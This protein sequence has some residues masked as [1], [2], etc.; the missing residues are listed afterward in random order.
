MAGHSEENKDNAL[1]GQ[2]I[3]RRRMELGL[4]RE[5]L[6]E[7][8]EVSVQFISDIERGNKSMT[9]RT[10]KRLANALDVSSD[11]IVFGINRSVTTDPITHLLTLLSPRQLECAQ[12]ILRQLVRMAEIDDERP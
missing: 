10:L 5:K 1:V 6:S 9:I 3:R 12:E 8:S 7:L 4:S 11:Y 2:R